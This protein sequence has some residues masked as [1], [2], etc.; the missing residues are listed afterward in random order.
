MDSEIKLGL[1]NLH[2]AFLNAALMEREKWDAPIDPD[3]RRFPIYDHGRFERLWVTFLYVLIEAW[4]SPQ[5]DRV[6][7]YVASVASIDELTS[8]LA[9]G[10]GDGSVAK[11]KETRNYMC[12]RDRRELGRWPASRLRAAR[13]PHEASRRIL[14]GT[15]CGDARGTER[16]LT[17]ASRPT[18][19][20]MRAAHRH[21]VRCARTASGHGAC[22][23]T[24]AE[25]DVAQV[26]SKTSPGW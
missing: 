8:L 21:A 23:V 15:S 11:M 19:K 1:L 5:M 3:P 17:C 24:A 13:V 6:R 18:R 10:Q 16:C 9:A 14:E 22:D 25:W 20:K 12:H 26:I 2:D 7:A 4:Q